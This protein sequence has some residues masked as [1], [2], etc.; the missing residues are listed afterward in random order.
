VGAGF[1]VVNGVDDGV[2]VV[3]GRGVADE[4]D[5][6][7]GEEVVVDVSEGVAPMDSDWVGNDDA[8]GD[9]LGDALS[10]GVDVMVT[11]EVPEVVGVTV[12]DLVGVIV[13]LEDGVGV[14]VCDEEGRGRQL[15]PEHVSLVRSQHTHTIPLQQQPGGLHIVIKLAH[16]SACTCVKIT[17]KDSITTKIVDPIPFNEDCHKRI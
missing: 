13:P 14:I 4:E 6:G 11:L 7:D 15:P 5:V 10:D 17:K 3:V 9:V 1:N 2:G 12:G 8:L 16:V